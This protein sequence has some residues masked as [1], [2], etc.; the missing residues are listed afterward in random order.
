M[1][2]LNDRCFCWFPAA[3]LVPLRRAPTWRLYTKLYKFRW[4]CLWN[5]AAVK[6]PTDLNLGDVF[7]LS[8]IYHIPDSWLNLLNGYDFYFQCKPPI[9]KL[10]CI[11]PQ[12]ENDF[13]QFWTKHQS[14]FLKI[15]ITQPPIPLFGQRINRVWISWIAISQYY[16]ICEF[17]LILADIYSIPMLTTI[18]PVSLID[19]VQRTPQLVVIS[20]GTGLVWYSFVS[21]R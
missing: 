18:S 3:M 8:I 16:A 21:E 2:K 20:F 19:S 6:N 12:A 17:R 15:W 13:P 14:F 11:V 9:L 7:N 10:H 4:N 1:A 5:N